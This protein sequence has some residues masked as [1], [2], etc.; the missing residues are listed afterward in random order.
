MINEC[1]WNSPSKQMNLFDY[2]SYSEADLGLLQDPALTAFSRYLLSQRAPP[3]M[4]Q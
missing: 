2:L 1:F 4:L 3:W